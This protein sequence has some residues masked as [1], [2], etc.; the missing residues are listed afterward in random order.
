MSHYDPANSLVRLQALIVELREE[1]APAARPD[2]KRIVEILADIRMHTGDMRVWAYNNF[3][4]K[5]VN[6]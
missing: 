6:D 5:E 4:I 1:L 3:K 2:A